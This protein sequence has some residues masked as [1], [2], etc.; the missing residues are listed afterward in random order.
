MNEAIIGILSGIGSGLL[1]ALINYYFTHRSLLDR[2]KIESERR[3]TELRGKLITDI[4]AAFED[5]R[6]NYERIREGKPLDPRFEIRGHETIFLTNILRDLRVQKPLLTETFHGLLMEQHEAAGA[7]AQA[8]R[9]DH[10]TWQ[11]AIARWEEVR[12][13]ISK[14]IEAQFC[15]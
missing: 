14:A 5:V 4:V 2:L 7:L 1:V 12:E 15:K 9:A 8:I 6:I 3:R 11:T 10:G 13:R